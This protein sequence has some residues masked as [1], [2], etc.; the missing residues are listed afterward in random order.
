MTWSWTM[1]KTAEES[2]VL[3]GT[4]PAGVE[5]GRRTFARGEP[6]LAGPAVRGGVT[7]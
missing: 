5:G 1:R 3:L 7:A 4:S 2:T 6:R